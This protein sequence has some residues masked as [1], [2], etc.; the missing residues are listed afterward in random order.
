[1]NE[2][3]QSEQKKE[4]PIFTTPKIESHE[5]TVQNALNTPVCPQDPETPGDCGLY[6]E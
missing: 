6:L 1:M 3:K 4:K 2:N 5:I